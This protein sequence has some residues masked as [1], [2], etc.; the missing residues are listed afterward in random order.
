VTDG[1][2]SLA[3]YQLVANACN[4]PVSGACP[5]GATTEPTYIERQLSRTVVR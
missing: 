5:N 1:A 4:A 2:A 3:F